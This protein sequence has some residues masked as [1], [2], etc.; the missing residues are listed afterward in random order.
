[1][2]YYQKL[3]ENIKVKDIKYNLK[4]IDIFLVILLLIIL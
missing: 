4:K 2:N 1:M 3:P